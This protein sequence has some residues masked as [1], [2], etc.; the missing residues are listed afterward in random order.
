MGVFLDM[1][2]NDKQTP[3]GPLANENYAREVM[4]LFSIGLQ[5]LNP[6]GSVKLDANGNPI[7]TYSEAQV[8]EFARVFTGWTYA[9]PDGSPV[10]EH[11][12][13]Y[14]GSF[15]AP[16]EHLH[17]TGTKTLL[18]GW[19]APAGQSAHDDVMMAVANLYWHPNVGPF[20]GRQ[21]IQQFVTSDP[22]P[23]YVARVAAAF[24]DNGHGVRGDTKAVLKSVL[25]DPEALNPP[26]GNSGK[27]REPVLYAIALVRQI[28]G[29]VPDHPF[30]SD[31]AQ[32]M[33]QKLLF[34][35]SVF[36]YFSPSYREPSTKLA[37]PEFQL[38]NGQT[39]LE[40]ANYAGR[41]IYGWFGDE[42]KLDLARFY[43][44]APD[45]DHLL[46][47]ADRELLGSNL[48]DAMFATIRKALVKY[49]NL[50]ERAR[51]ALYLVATAPAF[52]VTQ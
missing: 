10:T 47:L 8:K 14:F 17:D 22:S 29:T 11:T 3:G 5:Q 15:M 41:L 37:A 27:M 19:V 9:H 31:S 50:E 2:N 52:Q 24:A 43:E 32:N 6:D 4:Q 35:P 21:L 16:V 51:A 28:G 33:G 13:G 48:T 44:A 42:V 12:D 36:S 7:P 30:M 20:I 46:Y 40:R 45:V 39:A 38:Y 49:D 26:A 1:V 25:L 23:A 34:A 18:N